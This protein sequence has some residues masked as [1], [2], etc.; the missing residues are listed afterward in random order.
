MNK[1]KVTDQLA[2]IVQ[3][4]NRSFKK[5]M[6]ETGCQANFGWL[7]NPNT[8]FKMMEIQDVNLIVYRKP[9]P[10]GETLAK[11]LEKSQPK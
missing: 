4:F 5:W 8:G 3:D 10:G 7:Y 1:E 2:C 11:I 6:E 9:P